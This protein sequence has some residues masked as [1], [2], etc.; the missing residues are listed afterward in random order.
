[1]KRPFTGA[2]LLLAAGVAV[3]A[4]IAVPHRMRL[5]AAA[6]RATTIAATGPVSAGAVAQLVVN[7]AGGAQPDATPAPTPA[8]PFWPAP[9][10]F[11]TSGDDTTD[12]G[13]GA[14]ATPAGPSAPDPNAPLPSP[15][16]AAATPESWVAGGP[17]TLAANDVLE[18]A[19]SLL[20]VP[21]VWGGNSADGMDCSA[22]VSRAWGLTRQTTDT[23]PGFA[24]AVAKDDLLPGDIMNLTTGQDPR[25]YG[26][27]RI[28]AAWASAGH[29][30]AW[31]YEETPRQSIYH[32]IA[33]DPRYTPMR[34]TNVQAQDTVAPLIE[35]PVAVPRSATG[36][37]AGGSGGSG[38]EHGTRAWTG[39]PRVFAAPAAGATAPSGGSSPSDAFVSSLFA[40]GWMRHDGDDD[41]GTGGASDGGNAAS[42]LPVA[43]KQTTAIPTSGAATATPAPLFAW[44]APGVT[45]GATPQASAVTPSSGSDRDDTDRNGRRAWLSG[46]SRPAPRAG[47]T[48]A[49]T[50]T[51]RPLT[52]ATP[53]ATATPWTTATP[54][55][56]ATPQPARAS[57][58]TRTWN[59]DRWSPDAD[60]TSTATPVPTAAPATATPPPESTPEPV[61][62]L[63]LTTWTSVGAT[64]AAAAPAP[65]VTPRHEETT[66]RRRATTP[67][68]RTPT[69]T[70]TPRA[71]ATPRPT[72]AASAPA[73]AR[74]RTQPHQPSAPPPALSAAPNAR[75]GSKRRRGHGRGD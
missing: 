32:V 74:S 57:R 13:P 16:V 9:D 28:F 36:G 71:T 68:T 10:P 51:P 23:L 25:G 64:P 21:Y 18:M 43:T 67:S 30:R 73:P 37:A 33:Y 62:P 39:R 38:G 70:P 69:P 8:L 35:A 40:H 49:A 48:P 31:V 6:A 14:S 7:Q 26:H 27:V 34:R 22:Y 44:T 54:R 55:P 5:D 50:A 45:A 19:K 12:P 20:G 15:P 75:R 42:R 3:F 59:R 11:A 72:R 4:S 61:A 65:T 60:G 53:R 1:M 46:W 24:T 2:T 66:G 52:M 29:D 17:P 41:G 58:R 47:A 63:R 56:S